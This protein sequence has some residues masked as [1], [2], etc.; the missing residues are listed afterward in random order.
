MT[1][2]AGNK[3]TPDGLSPACVR[4]ANLSFKSNIPVSAYAP[5]QHTKLAAL[6]GQ[7]KQAAYSACRAL[8]GGGEGSRVPLNSKK[9]IRGGGQLTLSLPRTCQSLGEHTSDSA[10]NS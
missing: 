2:S 8:F 5:S 10:H 9:Q 3:N 7:V 1:L 4:S 6:S